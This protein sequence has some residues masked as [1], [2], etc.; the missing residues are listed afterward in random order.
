[1]GAVDSLPKQKKRLKIAL[2]MNREEY[3][4]YMREYNKAHK[5]VKGAMSSVPF[6]GE[7]YD[8]RDLLVQPTGI[9]FKG[10]LEP[11]CCDFFGCGKTLTLQEKL[12]GTKCINH[13]KKKQVT[14]ASRFVSYPINK[15]IA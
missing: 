15:K 3:L 7:Q 12:F 10:N 8:H 1:M 9:N 14:D 11:I 2:K 5:R 6:I 4:R 13:Q